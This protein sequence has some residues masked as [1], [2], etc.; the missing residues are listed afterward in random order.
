[1]R[2]EIVDAITALGPCS[3][4]ELAVHLGRAADSLYFHVNK[5]VKVGLVQ[6]LE[7]RQTGRHVWTVYAMPGRF[8][9]LVYRPELAR[10]ISR[11]VSGA[12]RLS[13]REFQTAI[14][15]SQPRV[16]GPLRNL[17]GG[18]IKG[19]LSDDDLAQVNRLLAR[20]FRLFHRRGPG[21][22]RQCHSLAWVLTPAQV[23]SRSKTTTP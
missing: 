18:R 22:G 15:R 1:M 5:L 11:V 16:E 17:W 6:E 21:P 2:Q 19:W 4:T 13:L 10:S 23:R 7:K 3:I 12:L 14:T 8:A 9:R 20:L